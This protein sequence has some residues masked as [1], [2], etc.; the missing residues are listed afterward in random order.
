MR[1]LFFTLLFSILPFLSVFAQSK[2]APNEAFWNQLTTLCG[3]A[4][5]AQVIAAPE[6]DSFRG[7]ELLMHVRYCSD[8]EI[9]I[10]FFV[11]DDRSRTWIFTKSNSAITLKHDHRHEDGSE[12]EIT[13]YGGT[14]PNVGVS[15]IQFFPADVE[16]ANLIPAAATN[17]WWIEIENE[18]FTYNL[19]RLGTDRFFS[20]KF[21]LTST[22]EIPEAPWGWDK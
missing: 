9:R 6:N 4:Y 12:D 16:T 10:P 2:S 8:T 21:D 5:S 7:Q 13:Q 17:V 14:S 3:N 18:Y 19:R 11:G 1:S 15:N 22:I 20:I